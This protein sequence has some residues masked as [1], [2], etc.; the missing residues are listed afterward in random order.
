VSEA[1]ADSRRRTRARAPSDDSV[2][3]RISPRAARTRGAILKAAE[4]LFASRGFDATRLED[5]AEVVG[6]RRASIVYY[7]RDKPALYDAVLE[8]AFAGL[9]DRLAPALLADREPAACIEAAVAA[10][11]DYLG[12]RPTFG[13][14][15][16]REAAEARPERRAPLLEKIEPLHALA[17]RF[18]ES[19]RGDG[20]PRLPS[21][22]PA[23][24]ASTIAGASVFF[25]AALPAL[26]P[27]DDFDPLAPEHLEALRSEAL[28][29]TRSFL[30]S[31]AEVAGTTTR[32]P[33]S[34][35]RRNRG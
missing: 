33:A 24:M 8:D 4:P 27:E 12:E 13:R 5:V 28:R 23:H 16:L 29:I 31:A 14:L 11:I 2:P 26:V 15:L 10:W 18:L 21:L 35:E 34:P 1:Q 30:G 3:G 25:V 9:R 20:M 6:I 22:G 7:F 19:R 17:R 32:R